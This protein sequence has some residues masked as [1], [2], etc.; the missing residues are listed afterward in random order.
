VRNLNTQLAVESG[1]VQAVR[2]I[3]WDIYP[4]EILGIVGESGS[5]KSVSVSSLL[6]L[7]PSPPAIVSGAVIYNGQDLLTLPE[8]KMRRIRGREISMIFQDPMTSFNPVK[9]IGSQISEAIRVHH[10]SVSRRA[11]RA[12]S[13]E[14]LAMVGG[15]TPGRR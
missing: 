6:R 14:L 10:R 7:L 2:G 12:P 3:S 13:Q 9:T 8:R 11:A 1:T 15:P 4:G 5:G